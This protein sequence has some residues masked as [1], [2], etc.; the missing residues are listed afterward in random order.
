MNGY[1]E[2]ALETIRPRPR[3][4][5]KSCDQKKLQELADSIKQKG[6]IEPIIV[7]IV[8]GKAGYEIVAGDRR[9][10]AS[11]LAGLTGIPAIIRELTD[12]EAYDFMLVE[13]LQREDLTERE[14]AESFKAYLGRHGEDGIP[15]L[16][17]KTGISPAYI[18]SRVRVLELPANVLKAWDSGKLVYGHLQQLLRIA[19][20][21][22]ALKEITNRLMRSANYGD[23][24]LATVH[25]LH[26][27]INDLAPALSGAFFPMKEACAGWK[28]VV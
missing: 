4:P 24:E 28:S 11:K 15:N 3:N 26:G 13:N 1:V 7:R 2:L 10:K 17:E 22:Q 14:E 23:A 8:K 6:V 19:G 20:D 18:R 12:D 25:Q 27:W 5:R 16:A 21:P 9:F